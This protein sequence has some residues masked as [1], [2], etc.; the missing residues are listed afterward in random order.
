VYIE[1][2]LEFDGEKK[3]CEV[4]EVIDRIRASLE[5]QI[6]KSRVSI[7]PTSTRK[8]GGTLP[9]KAIAE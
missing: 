1:I 7:V 6:P 3:M 9:D 2:F 5:A 8:C 4:Q